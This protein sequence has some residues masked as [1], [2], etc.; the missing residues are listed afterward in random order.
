M[1]SFTVSFPV[2][3]QKNS[4]HRL[5]LGILVAHAVRE[6]KDETVDVPT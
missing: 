6:K 1:V 4:L 5:R 3:R 2:K